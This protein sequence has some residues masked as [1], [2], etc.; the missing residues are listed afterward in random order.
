MT[1]YILIVQ[2]IFDV[3]FQYSI[4]TKH[5][6][7]LLKKLI[8]LSL[9]YIDRERVWNR[10]FDSSSDDHYVDW[11][12]VS[13]DC[14]ALRDIFFWLPVIEACHWKDINL[15]ERD[16][17]PIMHMK[18]SLRKAGLDTENN[19]DLACQLLFI[20]L[21]QGISVL[22]AFEMLTNRLFKRNT[23]QASA[24]LLANISE[25][26][27]RP[28]EYE[29]CLIEILSSKYMTVDTAQFEKN[30]ASL[31]QHE[32]EVLELKQT[33]QK[34]LMTCGRPVLRDLLE[35][36]EEDK[37]N[38]DIRL[39]T[40]ESYAAFCM[41]HQFPNVMS[42]ITKQKLYFLAAQTKWDWQTYVQILIGHQGELSEQVFLFPNVLFFCKSK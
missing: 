38:L 25:V 33:R 30:L 6:D 29:E 2:R 8:I 4:N 31:K 39:Q 32:A 9:K 27:H 37:L 22:Y 23:S 24:V 12:L 26:L 13:A 41:K 15:I 16:Y 35:R 18:K 42:D 10:I 40:W 3:A 19:Y 1:D 34:Q 21:L 5:I 36:T 11:S 14:N 28:D 17:P 7:I 20:H